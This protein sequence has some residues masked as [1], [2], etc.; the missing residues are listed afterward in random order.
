MTLTKTFSCKEV[1]EYFDVHINTVR[2][3]IKD[4][5]L[6]AVN[7]GKKYRIREQ[8]LEQFIEERQTANANA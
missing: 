6:N 1:A 7:T 3:W 4:G 2:R 8:D 5:D